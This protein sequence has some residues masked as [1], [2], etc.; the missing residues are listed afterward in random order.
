MLEIQA[1]RHAAQFDVEV[2]ADQ[3]ERDFLAAV[4]DGEINLAKSAAADAALDRIAGQGSGAA[5]IGEFQRPV[6][7]RLAIGL[8]GVRVHR[9]VSWFSGLTRF[10]IHESMA[11]TSPRTRKCQPPLSKDYDTRGRRPPNSE[12]L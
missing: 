1:M 2:V 12:P 3:L 6:A 9:F 8:G 5:G 7:R 11:G 4:A 10:F